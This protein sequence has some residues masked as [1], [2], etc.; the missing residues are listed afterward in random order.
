M[1]AS[2]SG[3]LDRDTARGWL[4]TAIAE[5]HIG[6]DEGG[7]PIGAA[8]FTRDGVLLGSGTTAACRMGTRRLTRKRQRFDRQA[9]GV[10]TGTPSW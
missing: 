4:A 7:I 2:R 3:D 8:L 6:L 1:S 10:A 9:A 5:A